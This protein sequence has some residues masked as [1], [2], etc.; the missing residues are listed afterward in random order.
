MTPEAAPGMGVVPMATRR[1]IDISTVLVQTYKT[2]S[3]SPGQMWTRNPRE[4]SFSTVIAIAIGRN[5]S[6]DIS[7]APDQKQG[8]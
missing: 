8:L 1:D 7:G 3:E 2:I 6:G 4:E 5:I